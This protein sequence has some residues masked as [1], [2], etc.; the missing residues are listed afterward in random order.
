MKPGLYTNP[1]GG[2]LVPLLLSLMVAGAVAWVVF[3]PR[4]SDNIQ[5]PQPI[6]L[7]GNTMGGT[8]SLKLPQLPPGQTTEQSQCSIGQGA[9]DARFPA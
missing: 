5:A 6:A 4:Q 7:T 8:W 1:A 2:K 3:R 9:F